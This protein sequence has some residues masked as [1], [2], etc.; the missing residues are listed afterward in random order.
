MRYRICARE[1]RS[2][3]LLLKATL[4]FRFLNLSPLRT[5]SMRG[6]IFIKTASGFILKTFG[7][8]ADSNALVWSDDDG[9]SGTINLLNVTEIILPGKNADLRIHLV[10][11]DGTT[12]KLLVDNIEAREHWT[13]CIQS[14]CRENWSNIE[15]SQV[16]AIAT[17]LNFNTS[18]VQFCVRWLKS[19]HGDG[20]LAAPDVKNFIQDISSSREHAVIGINAFFDRHFPHNTRSATAATE[21]VSMPV[22]FEWISQLCELGHFGIAELC[23]LQPAEV[24]N[25]EYAVESLHVSCSSVSDGDLSCLGH[26]LNVREACRHSD[27]QEIASAASRQILHSALSKLLTGHS[28][29]TG[30]MLSIFVLVVALDCL[31]YVFS[32]ATSASCS[33]VQLLD[34]VARLSFRRFFYSSAALDIM[35]L[36]VNDSEQ[37]RMSC[38][39]ALTSAAEASGGTLCS[40]LVKSLVNGS[41]CVAVSVLIFCNSYLTSASPIAER[42][43]FAK[44]L[45]YAGVLD[46]VEA[47]RLRNRNYDVHV[48]L[49][50]FHDCISEIHINAPVSLH[51]APTGSLLASVSESAPHQSCRVL[52]QSLFCRLEKSDADSVK[53]FEDHLNLW[54]KLNPEQYVSTLLLMNKVL[55]HAVQGRPIPSETLTSLKALHKLHAKAANGSRSDESSRY[56][57]ESDS[58][59]H[60]AQTV[61]DSF[62][63]FGSSIFGSDADTD[64]FVL[65]NVVEFEKLKRQHAEALQEIRLLRE[66]I[67]VF[68]PDAKGSMQN[69]SSSH[70]ALDS[71]IHSAPPPSI[72]STH[73]N[74]SSPSTK[75]P[76]SQWLLKAS[77]SLFFPSILPFVSN[78]AFRTSLLAPFLNREATSCFPPMMLGR[79]WN[80]TSRLHLQSFYCAT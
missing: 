58:M 44:S 77:H 62:W 31:Q 4:F 45:R 40:A 63:D 59:A 3:V 50:L 61:V 60:V 9:S 80:Q 21:L 35:S 49:S 24:I 67:S 15:V 73:P 72:L 18:F 47:I 26:L 22:I 5:T 29:S 42:E 64:E 52:L 68:H 74:P 79:N 10:M 39:K 7:L 12:E 28:A 2:V 46:A 8:D 37:T 25:L 36:C 16:A 14:V 6:P 53:M 76:T 55:E 17:R 54:L 41:E 19:Y 75:R 38:L 23:A 70:V 30:S 57:S 13:R 71:K 43:S 11:T 27:E 56:A 65:K 51:S 69:C 32:C 34:A 66:S 48:Q 33:H 1:K 20:S 78:I